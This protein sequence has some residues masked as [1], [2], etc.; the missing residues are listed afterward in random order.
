LKNASQER[1]AITAA[2]R[3]KKLTDGFR[4]NFDGVFVPPCDRIL[5]DFR[6]IYFAYSATSNYLFSDLSINVPQGKIVAILANQGSGRRTFMRMVAQCIFPSKGLVFFPSH[7]RV[8]YVSQEVMLLDLS[9]WQ[10]LTFGSGEDADPWRVETILERMDMKFTLSLCR[11]DID[12]V[13]D[14]WRAKASSMANGDEET[15]ENVHPRES[16]DQASK[17]LDSISYTEQAKIHL[18]R[19]LIMNPEIL[20][21]HRPLSHPDGQQDQRETMEVIRE[22]NTNRGLGLPKELV[23]RRRPRSVFMSPETVAQARQADVVWLLQGGTCEAF[24]PN[25]DKIANLYAAERYYD[26][27]DA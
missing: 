25:D 13:K 24:K 5:L 11:H 17:K 16:H 27:D 15:D 23:H 8:L 21:L 6:G 22:H 19:A 2:E 18:A 14:R 26:E 12:K 9:V 3:A 10:N 20:V 4:Q 7:C 1:R